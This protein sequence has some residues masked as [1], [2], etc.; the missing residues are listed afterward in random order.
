MHPFCLRRTSIQPR[1][2]QQACRLASTKRTVQRRNPAN[3]QRGRIP[4]ERPLPYRPPPQRQTKVDEDD[5]DSI[6]WFE[7]DVET[8]AVR[9]VA[10]NPEEMEAKKLRQQIK[11]LEAELQDY[12]SADGGL[13]SETFLAGLTPEERAKVQDALRRKKEEDK[14]MTKGLEISLELP[15]TSIPLLKRLNTSLRES[16]LEPD[17]VDR[18]KT[19]WRW[20]SRAKYSIPA[21]PRMIPQQAWDVLWRTQSVWHPTN[22]DRVSKVNELL[23]DMISVD[24]ALTP[25]QK[26]EHIEALLLQDKQQEARDVWESEYS[27]SG[28]TDAEMLA[29]GVRLHVVVDDLPRAQ[30]LL[31]QYLEQNSSNDPRVILQVLSAHAQIGNDHMAFALYLLLRSRLGAKMTMDDYDS[32]VLT[33][34]EQDKRD[35]ALAVFRDMML[36][37][38][39]AIEQR[40]LSTRKENELYEAVFHRMNALRSYAVNPKEVNSISLSAVSALP[41]EWQNKYFFASWLKKLIGMG[42]ID[43]AA[44][45]IELMYERGVQPDPKHLNGLIGAWLRSGNPDLQNKAEQLA[46][47][48]IQQRLEFTWRRRASKRGEPMPSV[49]SNTTETR[50]SIPLHVGRPVSRATIETFNILM[51]HYLVKEKWAYMHH[52][53]NLLR[54]AELHMDSFFMNHLLSVD[55]HTKGQRDVWRSFVK[56]A[57]IVNPDVETYNLL[58]TCCLRNLD[59]FKTPLDQRAGFPTPRQLFSVMTTWHSSL[60]AKAR[61]QA[62][63]GISENQEMYAKVVQAFLLEKDFAGALVAMHG[64]SR[65][66]ALYPSPEIARLIT[67]AVANLNHPALTNTTP[68][69]TIR[70]RG[71]RQQIPLSQQRLESVGKVLE[72]IA[73]KRNQDAIE[74]G[75]VVSEMDEETRASENLDLLSEFVRVVMVRSSGSAEDVE[76]TIELAAREMGLKGLQTGDVDASNVS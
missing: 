31:Q 65:L 66:F 20:Y 52:L 15:P 63:A 42:E 34:L 60:D 36:Q 62:A 2:F 39:Q 72:A 21:L 33:F 53:H 4:A 40:L 12:K 30:T 26:R 45:V 46:W 38:N 16:A 35:L 56:H 67:V 29:V 41:A 13:S 73:N 5:E 11:E 55:L 27:S 43:A 44:K 71:R 9:R 1:L 50:I 14:A 28:G 24:H 18:R 17:D 32:V 70:A 64:I 22:P 25:V 19:L 48:M 51:L 8:G 6:R 49:Q 69:P 76:P 47:S 75:V 7:K 23:E 54:P 58:W 59:R 3:N 68:A 10:G 37:G 74:H 57:R 61:A